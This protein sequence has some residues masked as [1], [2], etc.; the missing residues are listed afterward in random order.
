MRSV[1]RLSAV[2]ALAMAII[3]LVASTGSAASEENVHFFQGVKT[4]APRSNTVPHI[5][6]VLTTSNVAILQGASVAY[7]DDPLVFAE[8]APGRVDSDVRLTTADGSGSANGH[9]TFYFSTGT[10]LCSYRNGGGELAG[11]RAE[12]TV[13]TVD[14]KA[15]MYSVIGKY[16][17]GG[18]GA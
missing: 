9:C 13:G 4:C 5:V 2:G 11:F 10:G 15:R 18:N 16:W 7:V 8:P 1:L 17:L 14:A 3:A 6:C 12:F